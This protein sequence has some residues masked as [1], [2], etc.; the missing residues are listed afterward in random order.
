MNDEIRAMEGEMDCLEEHR[1]I[2]ERG[3][4]E[5]F[6]PLKIA[7]ECLVQVRERDLSKDIKM[8]CW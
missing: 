2:L 7:E 1:R 6:K 8:T 4:H 3:F 5:T